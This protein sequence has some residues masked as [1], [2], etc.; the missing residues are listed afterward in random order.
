[1]GAAIEP[2]AGFIVAK[3]RA[4]RNLL[5]EGLVEGLQKAVQLLQ[6]LG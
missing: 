2:S 3:D 1:M 5:A 6:S 4:F